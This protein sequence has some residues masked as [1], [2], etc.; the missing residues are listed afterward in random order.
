MDD[1]NL[2]TVY[3]KAKWLFMGVFMAQF[4]TT[5]TSV[6]DGTQNVAWPTG[7]AKMQAL[8]LKSTTEKAAMADIA[9]NVDGKLE[10]MPDPAQ[11]V[12]YPQR[13]SCSE[14]AMLEI[15]TIYLTH[16]KKN[17]PS[18]DQV[19]N[20]T[21]RF[22]PTFSEL[23]PYQDKA[24]VK[25]IVHDW[26]PELQIAKTVGVVY[27]AN[28]IT[29]TMIK[30]MPLHY[31]VKGTHGSSMTIIVRG[32]KA[33]CMVNDLA[34]KKGYCVTGDKTYTDRRT[35]WKMIRKNCAKWLAVDFGKDCRQPSY[36]TL[37]PGCIF[38]ASLADSTGAI[39]PDLKIF[40]FHGQ[41]FMLLHVN[42]RFGNYTSTLVTPK[43][44]RLPAAYGAK[45]QI[46]R[47]RCS[48][49]D[50][51]PVDLG[52]PESTIQRALKYAEDFAKLV[53]VP[54]LRVDFFVNSSHLIFAELTFTS[55]ACTTRFV[56]PEMDTL[57]GHVQL[58]PNS[59]IT[60]DCL[61]D[62]LKARCD[63][64]ASTPRRAAFRL[65]TATTNFKRNLKRYFYIVETN[66]TKT[67]TKT[68]ATHSSSGKVHCLVSGGNRWCRKE[69]LL[70][71]TKLGFV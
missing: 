47:K 48:E 25:L 35:H 11:L 39:P 26:A 41:P 2:F 34:K 59:N 13:K 14:A 50:D 27:D 3:S 51:T 71:S 67:K 68:A 57:L 10:K 58:H 43:L 62:R 23:R 15:E 65:K 30:K 18:F 22:N 31:V 56:P 70:I 60:S 64:G 69:H 8:S 37:Q 49:Y 53:G 21:Q 61:R 6:T 29:A 9:S 33:K 7:N 55:F 4:A 16:S 42:E 5:C 45:W 36:S 19:C 1:H 40:T 32:K 52:L 38:E 66:V 44:Q 46:Q 28:K 17:L 20:D 12:S 63:W 24:K 54:A